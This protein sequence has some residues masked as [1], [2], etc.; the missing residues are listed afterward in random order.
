MFDE[1]PMHYGSRVMVAE[2]G[3]KTVTEGLLSNFDYFQGVL[4][5]HGIGL[6]RKTVALAAANPHIADDLFPTQPEADSHS[7]KLDTLLADLEHS[8]RQLTRYIEQT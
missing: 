5:R 2:H 4:A 3:F 7:P 6:S 1:N 8:L